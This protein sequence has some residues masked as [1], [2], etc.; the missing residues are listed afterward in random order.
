MSVHHR[1]MSLDFP[2]ASHSEFCPERTRD[3]PVL[4]RSVSV[5]ALGSQTSQ[6]PGAPCDD[7]APGV[8]FR[9]YAE[10]RHP[11]AKK[12]F[13][14]SIPSPYVPLSTLRRR[15]YGR[16]RMTRG[17]CRSLVLHRLT[18][19]FSTLR[20]FIPGAR[21]EFYA[22]FNLPRWWRAPARNLPQYHEVDPSGGE[23]VL[24]RSR[25][26]PYSCKS[27]CA[28]FR[29]SDARNRQNVLCPGNSLTF[30]IPVS[31]GSWATKRI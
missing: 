31:M 4:V 22:L 6:D 2:L 1:I 30:R 9:I 11:E 12:I 26:T 10:R 15:P 28:T 7:G 18:L 17:R 14:G 16:L 25:S 27:C 23:Q 24:S 5:R 13:R 3:L 8:A 29:F 20:R 21:I 19:S